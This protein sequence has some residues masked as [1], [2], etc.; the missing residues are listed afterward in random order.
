MRRFPRTLCFADEPK[1]IFIQG[2]I[3]V[4]EFELAEIDGLAGKRNSMVSPGNVIE[5]GRRSV[6]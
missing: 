2:R 1:T 4:H 3:D 5:A 6:A